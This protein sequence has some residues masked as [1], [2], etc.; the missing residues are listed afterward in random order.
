[1]R[2]WIIQRHHEQ[3]PALSCI[4]SDSIALSYRVIKWMSDG[5]H[6]RTPLPYFQTHPGGLINPC[7][8]K[9]CKC[10]CIR[11]LQSLSRNGWPIKSRDAFRFEISF[12]GNWT[13]SSELISCFQ[14]PR[15]CR[16][17]CIQSPV[18][19]HFRLRS[20]FELLHRR[21]TASQGTMICFKGQTESY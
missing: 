6:L 13:C 20:R 4:M 7:R 5:Q 15:H 1:M 3:V 9:T 18:N 2:R 8:F 10:H 21:L 19:S 16:E 11:L 14:R 17:S 12:A